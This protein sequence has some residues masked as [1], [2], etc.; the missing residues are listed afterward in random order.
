[1]REDMDQKKVLIWALNAVE[2]LNNCTDLANL[3]RIMTTILIITMMV[4]INMVMMMMETMDRFIDWFS[5]Q[6]IEMQ[7]ITIDGTI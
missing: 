4:E 2:K 5:Y 6:A 1:M 3:F 7:L